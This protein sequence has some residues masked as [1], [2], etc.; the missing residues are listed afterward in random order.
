MRYGSLYDYK[1]YRNNAGYWVFSRTLT[2]LGSF[3]YD[4]STGKVISVSAHVL[5]SASMF[6]SARPSNCSYGTVSSCVV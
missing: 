5:S 6:V 4:Y 3:C 2:L 1:E